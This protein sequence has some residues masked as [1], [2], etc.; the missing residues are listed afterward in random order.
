MLSMTSL[1]VTA[2]GRLEAETGFFRKDAKNRMASEGFCLADKGSRL[3]LLDSRYRYVLA[4]YSLDFHPKYLHTYDYAPEQIWGTY[5]GSIKEE[6][7]LDGE[8]VFK[9]RCYFRVMLRR[10]DG[11]N[12]TE[13]EAQSIGEILEFSSPGTPESPK[14]FIEEVERVAKEVAEIREPG[15]LLL[16][17]LTDTHV[18]INGTWQDTVAN[19]QA[20]HKK[21]GADGLIHLGDLTD[22]T[23]SRDLTRH[24]VDSMLA[25]MESLQ[26]P[27]HIVL[28]N[29]DANYFHSNPEEMSLHEQSALY[30][31]GAAAYKK[32][33]DKTYYHVDCKDK[34][35]RMIFLSAYQNDARPRYGFDLAQ[36][37][38][39]RKTLSS[40]PE[41]WRVLV[42]SH[43]APLA[44][45][46]PWS[47][48]IRGGNLLARAL[49][50]SSAKILA[51]I[52]G[53]AHADYIYRGKE[54]VFPIISLGCAKCEDMAERK[55]EGS[56]TPQRELGKSSQELWDLLLV[57][58]S[59]KLYFLR[60]GA[61]K[62]R[63]I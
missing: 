35:L 15:D 7:Y 30:Q 27:V 10:V 32:D 47:E 25:D 4:L 43:D 3:R 14:I 63:I 54:T 9:E 46:D 50:G 23:V 13:E 58:P 42:F 22:G 45:L 8:Y 33:K 5:Q 20:L 2:G 44:Q 29:H 28:G 6:D 60:F 41:D 24:Y 12:L 37:E 61:G 62:S 17:L 55:V 38:W 57:K 59:G 21:V 1:K 36:I 39:V 19:L 51:F 16:F 40:T 48:K 49:N 18:V 53:H 11:E 31:R 56:F 34:K 26:I 52:H